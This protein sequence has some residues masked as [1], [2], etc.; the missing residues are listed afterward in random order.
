MENLFISGVYSNNG[1]VYG[2]VNISGS[3][4]L[5]GSTECK[6]FKTSG[7]SSVEGELKCES[8]SCSGATKILGGVLCTGIMKTSGAISV[9]NDVTAV[10]L[11]VSGSGKYGGCVRAEELVSISG[12]IQARGNVES[13][14]KVRLS[15][16]ARIDGDVIAEEITLSG[17]FDVTGLINGEKV[18]IILGRGGNQKKAGSVGGSEITVR[19]KK[20]DENF[21]AVLGFLEKLFSSD[22]D[23][24]TFETDVI[25][26]DVINL[27][28]TKANVVR[29][30]EINIGDGCE[31][32]R[33][34]FTG[35]VTYAENARIG[36]MVEI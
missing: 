34:E 2:D 21:G 33:V 22:N 1:G 26:G 23:V 19:C 25:E 24:P 10:E 3:G 27:E 20:E 28:N 14:K 11:H 15:G 7:A 13:G 12:A 30:K 4:K 29:G 16:S 17:G 9:E 8:F 35:K 6:S 32:G 5:R 31:I 18:E 36:E